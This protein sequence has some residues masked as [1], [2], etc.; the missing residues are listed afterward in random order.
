MEILKGIMPE[1]GFD[2]K[3]P[4]AL[5]LPVELKWILLSVALTRFS[6]LCLSR[7]AMNMGMD[8]AREVVYRG[9][10][11]LLNVI[12][13]GNFERVKEL[14]NIEG[15]NT[16]TAAKL[17]IMVDGIL[18]NVEEIVE[19]SPK[20]TVIRNVECRIWENRKHMNLENEFPCVIFCYESVKALNHMVNPKIKV[21]GEKPGSLIGIS[22]GGFNKHRLLGD[23]CCEVVYLLE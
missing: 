16:I 14:L 11:D 10:E 22:E 23:D 6:L 13:G 12:G 9:F 5:R 20:R 8:K 3:F 19:A 15:N 21:I 4:P 1:F 2:E 18:G 7:I 17:M